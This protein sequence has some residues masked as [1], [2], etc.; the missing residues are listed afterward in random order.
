MS[1]ARLISMGSTDGAAEKLMPPDTQPPI[2]S[3]RNLQVAFGQMRVVKDLSFDV[4]PGRTLA[5]VGESGSGKS[6]T[7]LS[8]LRLTDFTAGA[9]VS[10]EVLLRRRNG[11]VTNLMQLSS[12]ALRQV[13][14]GEVGMV[15]QEPM[16]SLNPVIPVGDQIAE[17]LRLH[18]ALVGNQ[19]ASRSKEL[20]KL[21]RLPDADRLMKN[22][23]H[24]L[25]GGMRQR[26]MIAMALA[27]SPRLI[28]ADEPTTALDVTIQ[29]QILTIMKDLQTETD[30]SV[31]F[32]THDMGVVA[33]IADDVM[34]MWR[35]EKV[36][37]N[38]VGEIFDHP[39]HPYT[40]AMLSSVP[41]LGDGANRRLP[42]RLPFF[43]MT[44]DTP[45]LV[46]EHREQDTA[47]Y[48]KPIVE[49]ENLTTRFDVA[50]TL[51]GK[52]TH[53]VHAVENISFSIYPGDTLALVGESGSGKSTVGRT[54]Q[55]L[56]KPTSGSIRFRGQDLQDMT[57][58]EQRTLRGKIQYIFQD[59]FSS[60]DPRLTVG[61]SVAEPILVHRLIR[62][63]SAIQER[64]AE[65]LEQVGLSP[66]AI[67]RYPHEF[68]GGQRQRICIARALA[69]KPELIIAD[70]SVSALDVSIQA[71]ILDLF[72]EIQ[73]KSKVAYLFVTHDMAVVEKIAHRVA[74]MYLGQ[75][76]EIGPRQ[77]IFESP[78]HPYTRRLLSAVPVADPSQR[79]STIRLEGEIPSPVRRV[80]HD[81]ITSEMVE[82]APWHFVARSEA[83]FV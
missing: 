80:G 31:V 58:A 27:S 68:S 9:V 12:H 6:V 78:Q 15:F 65:L 20:L 36:E 62:E 53:R 22:Y 45:R 44:G 75:I 23:P 70:E 42:L 5:I 24:Q 76:V 55:Q 25:S 7:A 38:S 8:I 79:C 4:M 56:V 29:A 46:G 32:I 18:S 83:V 3:V 54:L 35:G 34:V 30:A 47:D 50:K 66:A 74:V 14:G 77:S 33:Q 21:V 60:L 51:F 81:P 63:P 41:R 49:V 11:S 59:P 13:R 37:Q 16:T 40:K 48:S 72:M 19:V 43:V 39:R 17:A 28:I 69:S 26:V 2:L 10:G 57:P 67:N 52:V 73:E 71:Q 1:E 61:Y 82:V 64:V